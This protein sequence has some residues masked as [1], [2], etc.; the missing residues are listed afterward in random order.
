MFSTSENIRVTEHGVHGQVKL[1]VKT[2]LSWRR[3]LLAWAFARTVASTFFNERF[4]ADTA[5]NSLSPQASPTANVLSFAPP[6]VSPSPS[7][8]IISELSVIVFVVPIQL[9]LVFSAAYVAATQPVSIS[10]ANLAGISMHA[11]YDGSSYFPSS[12]N[13][14]SFYS[15]R[16]FCTGYI[17]AFVFC[18][19][20]LCIHANL[21]RSHYG[22]SVVPEPHNYQPSIFSARASCFQ[23]SFLKAGDFPFPQGSCA[24]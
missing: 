3:L 7:I 15:Y 17:R 12:I 2:S 14:H 23:Y 9:S 13:L 18:T 6:P 10:P 16:E 19:H 20:C 11:S 24:L 22:S 4:L 5:P 1:P 21:F 8:E